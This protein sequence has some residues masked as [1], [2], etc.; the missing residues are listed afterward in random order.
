M[1]YT[2]LLGL[3]GALSLNAGALADSAK[4]ALKWVPGTAYNYSQTQDMNMTMPMGGAQ[5][6]MTTTMLMNTK[7]T[8]SEDPKGIAVV[9]EYT[10]LKM[11][12]LMGGNPMMEYDSQ[13]PGGN[14]M[15]EQMFKPLLETKVKSIYD[16]DG[17][18]IGVEGLDNLKLNEAAGL[19]KESI[20]Q[21]AKQSSMMLPNKEVKVG[22]T[23]K[24]TMDMPMGKGAAGKIEF[25]MKLDSISGNIAKVS[26]TGT[27]DADV[28]DEGAKMKMEGKNIKGTYDFDTDMGQIKQMNM[29]MDF[30]MS[31]ADAGGMK[32]DGQA[33][34]SM[35]LTGTE[36]VK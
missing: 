5:M 29:D 34:T 8:A 11:T 22:E 7:N 20:E 9:I 16:K 13:Q 1:K 12:A 36:K 6:A 15:V 33:K 27:M 4:L 24:G 35:K 3:V 25:N 23:W 18:I 32:M 19:T 31:T 14:A 10:R 30:S 28:G 2:A 17:K 21:M 26:F